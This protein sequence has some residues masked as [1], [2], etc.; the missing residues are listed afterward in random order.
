MTGFL[1]L[2]RPKQWT[3]NLLVF[4]ALLFAG[5]V[6]DLRSDWRVLLAFVAM[7]ALSSA[8]YVF[9]DYFDRDRD[10]EHPTKRNR[11]IASGAVSTA[12]AIV[13]GL[14]LAC[15]AFAIGFY[16]GRW[17]VAILGG[18]LLLQV[19]Y[20]L[21]L[22]HVAVLDVFAIASGFV[23]RAALGAEAIQ[24]PISGWLVFCTASLA[25]MLGFAKR[26]SEFI[27]QGRSKEKSRECLSQYNR[28][29]LDMYVGVFAGVAAMT[30]GIYALQSD[31]AKKFPGLLVTVPFVLY[32]IS[33]YLLVV[34]TNDEGG[35]PEEVLLK[36]WHVIVSVVGFCLAVVFAVRGGTVP[37]IR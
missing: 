18:Y 11:P 2:A 12:A 16:L 28:F 10:R 37:I 21:W 9:N 23:I 27:K 13:F 36:D 8:T 26:R 17:V 15:A 4:A 22:K 31:T 25:L 35:E 29:V 20:N 5:A 32:G 33:R 6:P 19:F 30:Y 7:C 24:V 3:K 1:R 34:F 14:V